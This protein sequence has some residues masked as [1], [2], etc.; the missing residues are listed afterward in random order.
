[1][2]RK[3]RETEDRSQSEAKRRRH[4]EQAAVNFPSAEVRFTRLMLL[5]TRPMYW[6]PRPV[7]YSER[8]K[9]FL[10][11]LLDRQKPGYAAVLLQGDT[12]WKVGDQAISL[13]RTVYE[14]LWLPLSVQ[15]SVSQISSQLAFRGLVQHKMGIFL[16]S[17]RFLAC[18]ERR[19]PIE[20]GKYI[21]PDAFYIGLSIDWSHPNSLVWSPQLRV[22][23]FWPISRTFAPEPP[24]EYAEP[25]SVSPSE[26]AGILGDW[27]WKV[28]EKDFT[29]LRFHFDLGSVDMLFEGQHLLPPVFYYAEPDPLP[30]EPEALLE[31]PHRSVLETLC[32]P[33]LG[34]ED[35]RSAD[36]A[37]AVLENNLFTLRR[38]IVRSEGTQAYYLILPW[39]QDSSERVEVE[40]ELV[41][42]ADNWFFVEFALGFQAYDLLTDVDLWVSPMRLWE[43]R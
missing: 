33:L 10:I 14:R 29:K 20:L 22:S 28:V 40:R 31:F 36:V 21:R 15:L 1:M 9:D 16:D 32:Q 42:V 37:G 24:Q 5:H 18:C 2:S 3:K 8:L 25:F 41:F 43:E 12:E 6:E 23:N 13:V 17:D 30:S 38:E 26:A 11:H 27:F 4:E 39:W 34:T 7:Y 35:P 19:V